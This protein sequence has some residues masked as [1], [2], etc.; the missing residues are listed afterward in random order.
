MQEKTSKALH[1]PLIPDGSKSTL[2][3][4][5]PT[6][7][8]SGF[9]PIAARPKTTTTSNQLNDIYHLTKTACHSQTV[10]FARRNF[11]R[12]RAG[13]WHP[14]PYRARHPV[15]RPWNAENAAGRITRH[16]RLTTYRHDTVSL[17]SHASKAAENLRSTDPKSSN[18]Q[19]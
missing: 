13:V 7:R 19:I 10:H 12:Y 3:R 8:I 2:K 9:A 16:L 1:R 15:G 5:Y 17:S 14:C 4:S 6:S 11:R 18:K